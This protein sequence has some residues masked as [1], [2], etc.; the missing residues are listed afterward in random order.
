MLIYS[1]MTLY[2]APSISIIV[3]GRKSFDEMLA[4]A[5]IGQELPLCCIC[6]IDTGKH[7]V[8]VTAI[9]CNVDQHSEAY[10]QGSPGIESLSTGDER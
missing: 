5:R 3:P 1:P 10:S 7:L 9:C 4:A 2:G 8:C 6:T